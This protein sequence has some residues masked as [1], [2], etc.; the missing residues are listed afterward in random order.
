MKD[1]TN[2]NQPTHFAYT[3]ESY[4]EKNENSTWTKIGS[5]WNHQDGKGFNI[6]LGAF[7]VDGKLIIREVDIDEKPTA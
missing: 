7:P 1:N 5:C 2:K 6:V 3:V 4:G